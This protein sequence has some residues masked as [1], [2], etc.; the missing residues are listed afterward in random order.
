MAAVVTAVKY[1]ALAS[2]A[3]L[4]LLRARYAAPEYAMLDDVASATGGYAKRRAD[5]LAMSLWPS[6]GLDIHGFELKSARSDWLRELKNPAKAEESIT[7]Y[8]H[9]WW[10]VAGNP[11]V[12]RLDELPSSWGLLAAKT[13]KLYVLKPAPLRKVKPL[14]HLFLAALLRNVAEHYVPKSTV[15]ARADELERQRVAAHGEHEGQLKDQLA[16]LAEKV[17]EFERAS[18]VRINQG[19]RH[20]PEVGTAVRFVLDGGLKNQVGRMR[21]MLD[22]ARRFTEDLARLDAAMLAAAAHIE[23]KE[24]ATQV[25]DGDLAGMDIDDELRGASA[26]SLA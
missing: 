3:L 7:P 20:P 8:C 2:P 1:P 17:Y 4:T 12:V 21:G 24:H 15:F 26:T 16:K 18:G 22:Q 25:E 9:H 11:D 23:D 14:T 19:W 6:R 5:A 13:T 10:V